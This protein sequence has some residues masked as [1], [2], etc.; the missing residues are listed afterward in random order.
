MY[1][2]EVILTNLTVIG[3][4]PAVCG[5]TTLI[6]DDPMNGDKDRLKAVIAQ[7][8]DRIELSFGNGT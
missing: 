8:V 6:F 2:C 3:V 1:R 4:A 7:L 5:Q